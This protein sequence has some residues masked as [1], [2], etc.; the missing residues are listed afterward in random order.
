MIKIE[1][2]LPTSMQIT[3][4]EEQLFAAGALS[5]AAAEIRVFNRGEA[6]TET[7]RGVERVVHHSTQTKIEAIVP[8][9]LLPNITAI[10]TK[11]AEVLGG[12]A[13]PSFITNL[14]PPASAR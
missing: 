3:E 12:T 2:F 14:N 6:K 11:L 7:Y 10:F 4:F 8:D 5:V 1:A 13:F 9:E